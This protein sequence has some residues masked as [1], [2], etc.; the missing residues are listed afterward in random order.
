MK[1]KHKDLTPGFYHITSEQEPEPC[2]VNVYNCADLDGQLVAGFNPHD[3]AAIM[4]VWDF[5]DD[6][7]FT[8]VLITPVEKPMLKGEKGKLTAPE[9]VYGFAAWLTC[10]KNPITLSST[11]DASEICNLVD[12]FI[13]TNSLGEPRSNYCQ[14]LTHPAID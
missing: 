6:T 11:N 7:I 12:E 14:Y 9:A 10:R 4:P 5:T 3:G 8:P 2:L 13:R 1:D